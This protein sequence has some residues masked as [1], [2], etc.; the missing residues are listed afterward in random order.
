MLGGFWRGA[1]TGAAYAAVALAVF[2]I[3]DDP[4]EV[5]R[6]PAESALILAYVGVVAG[7]VGAACGALAGC[8]GGAALWAL[9]ELGPGGRRLRICAAVLGVALGW[10]VVDLA[11][12][13]GADP[14]VDSALTVLFWR[15]GPA[16]AGA[17]GALWQAARTR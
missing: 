11:A 14:D 7:S 17:L 1:V 3:A 15:A 6:D 5:L 8:L 16:A 4:A 12:A 13:M 9:A 10:F 2:L